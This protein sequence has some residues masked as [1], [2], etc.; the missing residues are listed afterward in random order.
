MALGRDGALW[1]RTRYG[2][3][4]LYRIQIPPLDKQRD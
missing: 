4:G 1:M 3:S 2:E